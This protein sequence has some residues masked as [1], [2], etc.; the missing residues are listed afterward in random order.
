VLLSLVH[1]NFLRNALNLIF[2]LDAVI[3]FDHQ[4][5]VH[6]SL[7]N[8]NQTIYVLYYFCVQT[9]LFKTNE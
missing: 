6:S 9:I 8:P 2:R 4:F 5:S 3:A 1:I 7:S